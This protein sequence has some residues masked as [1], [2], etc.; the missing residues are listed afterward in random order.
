MFLLCSLRSAA[1]LLSL[2][3]RVNDVCLNAKL[4]KWDL[5]C[6]VL[7]AFVKKSR[8]MMCDLRFVLRHVVCLLLHCDLPFCEVAA[9]FIVTWWVLVWCWSCGGATCWRLGAMCW[10][11][12]GDL[13]LCCCGGR[14]QPAFVTMSLA[15]FVCNLSLFAFGVWNNC[16]IAMS[17]CMVAQLLAF[18]P[19]SCF[20]IRT[21]SANI[22]WLHM[23]C[24]KDMLLTSGGSPCGFAQRIC[25]PHCGKYMCNILANTCVHLQW[26][27][28]WLV[29]CKFIFCVFSFCSSPVVLHHVNLHSALVRHIHSNICAKP[30]AGQHLVAFAKT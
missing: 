23:K 26:F 29:H 3:K 24:A 17:M 9:W 5:G 20:D 25:A 8:S 10:W 1:C 15:I 27:T 6:L 21:A 4:P 16:V 7:C 28:Q 13:A 12:V 30:L 19:S 2:S 18:G 22:T 14:L 11:F